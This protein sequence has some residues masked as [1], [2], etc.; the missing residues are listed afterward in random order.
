MPGLT[1]TAYACLDIAGAPVRVTVAGSW[2][3]SPS[4]RSFT[5]V[6]PLLSA[7]GPITFTLASSAKIQ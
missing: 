7:F 4:G 2:V 5:P 1:V 6:L 3:G